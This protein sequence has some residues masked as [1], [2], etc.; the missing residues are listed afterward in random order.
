MHTATVLEQMDI[1]GVPI[2][3]FYERTSYVSLEFLSFC[4][5]GMTVRL[6]QSKVSWEGPAE[7]GKT[8]AL[9][10]ISSGALHSRLVVLTT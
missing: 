6:C 1:S 7:L 2:N 9:H 10:S 4:L 5:L 8:P 3:D